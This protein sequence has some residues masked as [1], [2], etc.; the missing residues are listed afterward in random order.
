MEESSASCEQ[1]LVGAPLHPCSMENTSVK[2]F[3]PSEPVARPSLSLCA[4]LLARESSA[5]HKGKKGHKNS[6]LII[7]AACVLRWRGSA[8]MSCAPAMPGFSSLQIKAQFTTY[9]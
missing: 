2:A 8:A 7:K 5:R 4:V 9:I 1:R 6:Y 3:K